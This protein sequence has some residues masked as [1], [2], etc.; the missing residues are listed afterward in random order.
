MYNI[1]D[2]FYPLKKEEDAFYENEKKEVIIHQSI[3]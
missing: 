1:R 2:T 3:L